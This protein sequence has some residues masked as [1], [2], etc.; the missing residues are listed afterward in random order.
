MSGWRRK[1]RLALLALAVCVFWSCVPAW[2]QAAGN[3]IVLDGSFSD[4][5]GQ[6][7]LADRTGDAFLTGDITE[8]AWATNDNEDNLYFMIKR[9]WYNDVWDMAPAFYKVELDMNDNGIF[10]GG[11]DYY[12]LVAYFPHLDGMVFVNLCRANN[13]RVVASYSGYWGEA[14]TADWE[15]DL[16]DNWGE[17]LPQ[18]WWHA[19]P[20]EW[21]GTMPDNWGKWFHREWGRPFHGNWGNKFPGAWG[22]AF[23]EDCGGVPPKVGSKCEFSVPMDDLGM[24]PAQPIRMRVWSLVFWPDRVPDHG[25]IQWS[26]IPIMPVWVLAAI[27]VAC[28]A[29]GV[30]IIKKRRAA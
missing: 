13:G 25:D 11:N 26:P 8:F 12:L 1:K 9:N 5:D 15:S 18:N 28:L 2:A 7:N 19:F 29:A 17:A 3:D 16:P 21:D 4:W 24:Y 10:Q 30:I 27:F 22:D 14:L 20:D 6:A 23:P